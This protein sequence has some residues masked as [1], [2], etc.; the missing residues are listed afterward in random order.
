MKW[1]VVLVTIP[2]LI[3]FLSCSAEKQIKKVIDEF[4]DSVNNYD[5]DKLKSTISTHS[6]WSITDLQDKIYTDHLV[7]HVPLEYTDLIIDV[8]KPFADVE[9]TALYNKD[10]GPLIYTAW[11]VMREEE[12]FFS[13]LFPDWRIKEI[14]DLDD[15]NT[16]VWKKIKTLTE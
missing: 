11:F 3:L 8:D 14:Y 16:P 2:V 15:P 5:P 12:K 1:Y 9:S 10:I 13:F 4:E 7:D 6:D